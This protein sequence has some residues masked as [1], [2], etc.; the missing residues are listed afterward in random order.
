MWSRSRWRIAP[1]GSATA[2]LSWAG[3]DSLDA[4]LC[5]ASDDPDQPTL[6]TPV[7][8]GDFGE[9]VGQPAPDFELPDLDGQPH[10]LSEQLGQPVLL[11]YFATW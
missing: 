1:G 2:T 4:R 11:A 8:A 9:H 10:V 3:G 5:L 7:I 6:E